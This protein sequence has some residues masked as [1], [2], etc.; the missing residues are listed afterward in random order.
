[1]FFSTFWNMHLNFKTLIHHQQQYNVFI[2][3]SFVGVCPYLTYSINI[4]YV[5]FLACLV[6]TIQ[7]NRRKRASTITAYYIGHY[8]IETLMDGWMDRWRFGIFRWSL[9]NLNIFFPKACLFNCYL[10]QG[11]RK[12]IQPMLN[13]L[14]I[15]VDIDMLSFALVDILPGFNI[16]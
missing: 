10:M 4:L 9:H 3:K 16:I 2:V 13:R 6:R 8:G 11:K 12:I 7:M 15:H 1:M 14:H 5:S